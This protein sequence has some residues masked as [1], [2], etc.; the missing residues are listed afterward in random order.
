MHVRSKGKKD[1][2]EERLGDH[3]GWDWRHRRKGGGRE[4][5]VNASKRES[6]REIKPDGF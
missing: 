1:R 4:V 2:T 3:T 5:G 6:R